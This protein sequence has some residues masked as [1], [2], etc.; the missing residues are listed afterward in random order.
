MDPHT[1]ISCASIDTIYLFGGVTAVPESHTNLY[2]FNTKTSRLD[3]ILPSKDSI[4]PQ[5]RKNGSLIYS[6]SI[7]SS[8]QP[9]LIL[10]GGLSASNE[11][12]HYY[13]LGLE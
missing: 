13:N 6:Q 9:H 1:L 12:N 7:L 4:I 3:L 11:V 8:T 2:I 10:F 5:S